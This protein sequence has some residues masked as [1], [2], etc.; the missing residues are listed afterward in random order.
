MLLGQLV[1][2]SNKENIDSTIATIGHSNLV[3]PCIITLKYLLLNT[4]GRFDLHVSDM[5]SVADTN[6]DMN[7]TIEE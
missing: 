7:I 3:L 2:N 1:E 6:N 5:T 4:I